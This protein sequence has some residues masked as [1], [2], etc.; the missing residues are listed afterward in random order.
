MINGFSFAV[1]TIDL[2]MPNTGKDDGGGFIYLLVCG[3]FHDS[4]SSSG[5]MSNSGPSVN[6]KFEKM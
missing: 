6:I 5:Y 1:S 2:N 4:V 3:L